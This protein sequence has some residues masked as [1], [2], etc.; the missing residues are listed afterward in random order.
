MPYPR[1]AL[2]LLSLLIFPAALVQSG[3]V[4]AN[5]VSVRI[6]SL[7]HDFHGQ[8]AFYAKNLSTSETMEYH[9]DQ[10]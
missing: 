3:P 4:P 2:A 8:V 1:L 7:I 5:P 6:D 9:A 10:P